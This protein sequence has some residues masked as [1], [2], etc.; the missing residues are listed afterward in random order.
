MVCEAVPGYIGN[1]EM[2]WAEG[3]NLED[4]VLSFLDRNWGQ[5]NHIYQDNFYN[6]LAQTL[7]GRKVRVCGTVR[8]N[9]GIPRDL[10]GEGSAWK[11]G[12]QRSGEKVT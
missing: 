1:M 5:N 6:R 7:R 4:T 10:E 9:R 12:G 3:K 11:N 8:A 2:Y